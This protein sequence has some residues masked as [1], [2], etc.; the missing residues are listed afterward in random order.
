V[1]VRFAFALWVIA[2]VFAYCA[3]ADM[4]SPV[5]D[6]HLH[7]NA[8]A[9]GAYGVDEILSRLK[10]AGIERALVSSTPNDGTIALYEKDPTRIVPEL[11]PYRGGG[12]AGTWYQ[13]P[14]TVA[15]IETELKRGIYRSIGEFHL[16]GDQTDSPVVRR[17]VALAA[18]RGLPLHAHSDDAAVRGLYAIDPKITIVWAHAGMSAPPSLVRSMLDRFP[19]LRVE[20]SIRGPDIAPGGKLDEAW[21][22]LFLRYP[23]RFLIG[24]DTWTPSRW[25][26]LASENRF[27][28]AWLAQLPPEVA[29]KIAY[30]NGAR[31]FPK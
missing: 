27:A 9:R 30:R 14:S 18:E 24:T 26:E 7:Y 12:D 6:G 25:D 11:R 20:L 16:H 23:D 29:E 13:D 15:F 5:F 22:E 4:S 19:T 31:L 21:R 2:A 8:D 3:H 28:R 1:A 17:V 10:R